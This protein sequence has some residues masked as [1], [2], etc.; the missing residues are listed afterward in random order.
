MTPAR[1]QK[2]LF[3]RLLSGFAVVLAV[4]WLCALARISYQANSDMARFIGI[5]N[6]AYAKKYMIGAHAL[7]GAVPEIA[8]FVAANEKLRLEVS[9]QVGVPSEVRIFIW[10]GALLVYAT[11]GVALPPLPV[12]GAA[13][14]PLQEWLGHVEY[15]RSVGLTV[16]RYER[17]ETDWMFTPQGAG[18]LLTP[19][20]FSLPFML[21]P[22]W[23]IV[24]RG[25][26]PLHRIVRAI[27]QRSPSE[28]S[29][30]PASSYRE[31]SP[32]VE[33]VNRLMKRL[34]E[35]LAREQEFL[36][37]AAHELKTPLSV[38]QVNAH[39]LNVSEQPYERQEARE[40]LALGVAR[41]THTVHQLLALERV[42]GEP[43]AAPLPVYDFKQL[44]CD[45]LALSAP[46]A[47]ARGIEIDLRAPDSCSLPLHRESMAAMLDNLI[48]NAIKYSPDDSQ[49]RLVLAARD[50]G[51]ELRI[52]DQGPGIAAA[53]HHK[54]FERFY[55]APGQEKDGS[56]LG[57]AIAERAAQ[58]NGAT[59]RLAAGEQGRGLMVTVSLQGVPSASA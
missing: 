41:A 27:E 20:V 19:L 32:L 2:S 29:P 18:Y 22:A 51:A 44:L 34:S 50:Q 9:E 21:L 6:R 43:G 4:V 35:R 23:F 46:L 56:G 5:E 38:I 59:I 1:C 28:L 53:M 37:D 11:P 14:A 3:G 12:P 42:L 25:L 39:L 52:T 7:K 49:I 48:G 36:T 8:D 16:L 40:G 15:D 30:L 31:L 10:K 58:R 26:R 47:M 24:R 54:V 55:R 45:R 13:A 57:L 33:A 17:C